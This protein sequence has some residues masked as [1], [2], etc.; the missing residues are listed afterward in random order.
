MNIYLYEIS[1]TDKIVS[2]LN[3]ML[4]LVPKNSVFNPLPHSP[5]FYKSE[6]KN[7]VVEKEEVLLSSIF[8]FFP[9]TFYFLNNKSHV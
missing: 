2:K 3:F 5:E 7:I 1:I 8:S 4:I 9:S 6:R